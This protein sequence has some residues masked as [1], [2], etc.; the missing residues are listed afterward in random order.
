MNR[1]QN[2]D[3]F[4][5]K[6][7]LNV[8]NKT[9]R[10]RTSVG[11]F[12]SIITI[13]LTIL[14][15]Y[16]FS[17]NFRDTENPR[18]TISSELSNNFPKIVLRDQNF[19]PFFI[20]SGE[21]NFIINSTIVE[22]YFTIIAERMEFVI[23]PATETLQIKKIAQQKIIDCR[24][25]NLGEKNMTKFLEDSGSTF[26]H[27][28][29]FVFCPEELTNK[30]FWSVEGSA[31]SF[32]FSFIQIKFYPCSLPDAS[33]CASEDDMISM[34][35]IMS[36]THDTYNLKDKDNPTKR[37]YSTENIIFGL[38][39]SMSSIGTVRFKTYEVLDEDRDFFQPGLTKSFHSLGEIK[40]YS[41]LRQKVMYCSEEDIQSLT[42]T[43]YSDIRIRSGSEVVT[44]LR[45]YPKLFSTISEM[46]GFGD[47]IFIIIGFFYSFYNTFLFTRYIGNSTVWRNPKGKEKLRIYKDMTIEE[48]EL[49]K[50]RMRFFQDQM[51]GVDMMQNTAMLKGFFM[52]SFSPSYTKV[53]ETIP[54][55]RIY[56]S[57]SQQK[58]SSEI[59]KTEEDELSLDEAIKD[60]LGKEPVNEM[61][62]IV[63]ASLVKFLKDDG[64]KM[65][66]KT[67]V[68]HSPMKKIGAGSLRYARSH[69]MLPIKKRSRF[70]SKNLLISSKKIIP[71]SLFEN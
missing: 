43:P 60:V 11:A 34:T 37:L 25:A 61:E 31:N 14:G 17:S 44:V 50:L 58:A 51:N 48:N 57:Q 27:Q 22:K 54:L 33:K 39:P 40:T 63:K 67:K 23:D 20:M 26:I 8:S 62:K 3:I 49:R 32:P 68:N 65:K 28:M 64:N 9:E 55:L 7:S 46:G 69:K 35:I 18:V 45:V 52:A 16:I 10:F 21:N 71:K 66:A 41:Q 38:N 53:M 36:I 70:G 42:C 15:F 59:P 47:L 56:M 2:L 13:I 6:Y 30:E 5:Q 4:G 19:L 12:V 29:G 24:E 1:L